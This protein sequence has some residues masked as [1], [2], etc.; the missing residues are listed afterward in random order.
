ANPDHL[1]SFKAFKDRAFERY[2][3]RAKLFPF[4]K[5]LVSD[6]AKKYNLAIVSSTPGPLILRMLR[7]HGVGGFFAVVLDALGSSKEAELKNAVIQ[8]GGRSCRGK[9]F[10]SDTVGDLLLGSKL[11][12]ETLAVC[13]GFHEEKDLRKTNPEKVFLTPRALRNYLLKAA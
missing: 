3:R 7:N 2:Y 10:V 1:K 13:W 5:K 6:L 11:G 4:S 9:F 8:T 12:M